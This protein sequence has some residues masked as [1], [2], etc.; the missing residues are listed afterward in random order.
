MTPSEIRTA[1]QIAA[2]ET[3]ED[4]QLA[5]DSR[6][7][8]PDASDADPASDTSLPS[9]AGTGGDG[10]D[11]HGS[12][13]RRPAGP[14]IAL[15]LGVGLAFVGTWL[16]WQASNDD[17][18]AAAES[19][20]R[21]LIEATAAIETLNS[22]DHRDVI[23]DLKAWEDVTTG[24][25]HDQIAATDEVQRQQL[26]DALKVS[27]G[28]VVDAAV[29][30][31]DGP[32]ATVVAAVEITVTDDAAPESE[33]TLKRNRFSADLKLVDGQWKIENLQQVAVSLS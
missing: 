23:G 15:I 11:E 13:R 7:A 10:D 32:Q 19:R 5:S 3:E 17:Q 21:V 33:P 1:A 24:V 27:E 30:R 20:D 29:L 2:S 16:W 31:L 6:D 18:L 26:A 12:S 25:M 4:A 8:S 14:L 9:G 28:E 22:L